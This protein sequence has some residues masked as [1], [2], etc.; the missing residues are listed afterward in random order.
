MNDL[1]LPLAGFRSYDDGNIYGQGYAFYHSSSP[2]TGSNPNY[3][4]ILFFDTGYVDPGFYRN[5]AY[6][7]SIRCMSND[8][9][10]SMTIHP[11]G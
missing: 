11:N 8:L 6:G 9:S 1:R 5:R 2:R 3:S 10:P 4:W 7:Q